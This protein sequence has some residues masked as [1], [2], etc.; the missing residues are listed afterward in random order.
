MTAFYS[1]LLKPY[2]LATFL[3]Y[4]GLMGHFRQFLLGDISVLEFFSPY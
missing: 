2:V 4:E 3:C 1:Y